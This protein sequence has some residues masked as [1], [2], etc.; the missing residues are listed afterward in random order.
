MAGSG[1]GD[2]ERRLRGREAERRIEGAMGVATEEVEDDDAW[3][4]WLAAV[5]APVPLPPTAAL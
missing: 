1:A 4:S 2:G 5:V 3:C